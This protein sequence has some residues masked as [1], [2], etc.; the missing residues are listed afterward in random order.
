VWAGLLA[1]ISGTLE[2]ACNSAFSFTAPFLVLVRPL[3]HIMLLRRQGGQIK[4]VSARGAGRREI[5]R[6]SA[7]QIPLR[8]QTADHNWKFAIRTDKEK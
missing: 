6:V 1:V 2:S 3:F 8:A 7:F 4:R 5:R